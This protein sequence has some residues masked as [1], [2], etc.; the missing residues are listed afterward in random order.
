[1]QENMALISEINALRRE[2]KIMKQNQKE[3]DTHTIRIKRDTVS[4]DTNPPDSNRMIEMQKEE[5]KR[6]RARIAE[7]EASASLRPYS[8]ERLPPMDG[9]L[10]LQ[11]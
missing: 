5:I 9:V 3:K 7:L 6:Q 4:S 1:M 2:L 10:E 11:D 8:R